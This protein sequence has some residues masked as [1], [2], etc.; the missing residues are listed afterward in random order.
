MSDIQNFKITV[1]ICIFFHIKGIARTMVTQK[2]KYDK[3]PLVRFC[4]FD[5][6]I[7]SYKYLEVSVYLSAFLESNKVN[8][9]YKN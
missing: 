8:I 4:L 6:R 9:I 5:S 2:M 1:V 7:F 3:G